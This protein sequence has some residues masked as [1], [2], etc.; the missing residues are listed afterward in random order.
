VGNEDRCPRGFPASRPRTRAGSWSLFTEPARPPRKT[1]LTAREREGLA[2]IGRGLR[3]GEA[4][5]P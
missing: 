3:N 1:R 4:A 2:L 5:K